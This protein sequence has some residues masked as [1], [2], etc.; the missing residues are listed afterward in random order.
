[1]LSIALK[2]PAPILVSLQRPAQYLVQATRRVF[3]LNNI[4]VCSSGT[5]PIPWSS[6]TIFCLSSTLYSEIVDLEQTLLPI[7]SILLCKQTL[8]R[9]RNFRTVLPFSI[10]IS[11]LRLQ[12][13]LSEQDEIK[14]TTRST[15]PTAPACITYSQAQPTT[16]LGSTVLSY[17]CGPTQTTH[18]Y[19]ASATNAPASAATHTPISISHLPVYAYVGIG[20]GALVVISILSWILRKVFPA[21]PSP[22]HCR[23]CGSRKLSRH[24][25]KHGNPNGNVGRPCYI[26]TNSDCPNVRILKADQ[27]I[28]GWVTWD[29][30][31][32]VAATNPPCKC[33][34]PLRQD[35]AGEH[36]RYPGRSFWTCSTGACDYFSWLDVQRS[37]GNG[38]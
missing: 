27:H 9:D 28:T 10:T 36:S 23:H 37:W 3:A 2:A 16:G 4:R 8:E 21:K 7:R 26:C 20:F 11:S 32:G 35:V 15:D 13:T 29:D 19:L 24:V 17:S 34:R 33:G 30:N 12:L 5:E 6:S 31:V 25:V 38:Y 14:L 18:I 1:M 22:Y